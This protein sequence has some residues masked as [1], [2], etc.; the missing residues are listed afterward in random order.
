MY[1]SIPIE[2]TTGAVQVVICFIT[3]LAAVWGFLFTATR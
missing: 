2:M 1:P 3:A